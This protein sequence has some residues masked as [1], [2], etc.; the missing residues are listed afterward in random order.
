VPTAFAT[1]LILMR[2]MI[3]AWIV[4]IIQRKQIVSI[5][6]KKRKK[7]RRTSQIIKS[8]QAAQARGGL[9]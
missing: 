9:S 7:K 5:R 8:A 4:R 1:I 3:Y 6:K 2:D